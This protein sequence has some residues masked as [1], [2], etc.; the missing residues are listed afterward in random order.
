LI[1]PGA[2]IAAPLGLAFVAGFALNEAVLG[3]CDAG[4]GRTFNPE[5]WT[6]SDGNRS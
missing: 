5:T 2:S 6:L 3:D 4:P 1:S